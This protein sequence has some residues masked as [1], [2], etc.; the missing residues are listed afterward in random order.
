MSALPQRP[1]LAR[2][3]ALPRM[4][5]R[6]FDLIARRIFDVSAALAGLI[7]LAPLFT[8]IALAIRVE[9]SG[10]I[11]FSQVRLGQRG[12]HFRLYKF[13]KF[14]VRRDPHEQAVTL[15]NDARLTRLGKLLMQTKL[16]ELPQ[17]WNVLKGDMS[18]VGP[19][20]E[21]L[22]FAECFL[23]LY[24]QVLD[25]KPGIFGPNQVFFRNEGALYPADC[26]VER[27]YRDVLFP[28]KARVDLAYFPYRN[29][30]L[31]SA[32]IAR[33]TIAVFGWSPLPAKGSNW[34]E[35]VESWISHSA[36]R[37]WGGP[38]AEKRN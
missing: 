19:R 35:G 30:Y 31:D 4:K 15:A 8:L 32:W 27:F 12:R 36:Q 34:V 11:F 22:D 23:D 21:T 2:R 33:G 1:A 37:N 28:L 3:P 18:M 9:S 13:R 20:P 26:D 14:L 16:D 29:V 5:L 24:R 25:F 7:C 10:P 17:L 38:A 6:D